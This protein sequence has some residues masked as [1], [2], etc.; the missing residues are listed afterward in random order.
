M[1]ALFHWKRKRFPTA[2]AFQEI[3]DESGLRPNKI[4]VDECS[5]F[6]NRSI[7]SWLQDNDTETYSAHNEGKSVVAEIFIR[8]LKNKTY[9]Y[10]TSLSKNMYIY[11]LDYIVN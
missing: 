9:K 7:K 2:N 6:Y 8:T 4:W 3:L 10:M 1:H 5:E 11:I